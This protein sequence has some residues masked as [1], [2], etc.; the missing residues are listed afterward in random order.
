MIHIIKTIR[1]VLKD[2]PTIKGYCGDPARIYIVSKPVLNTA[3][4]SYP[5]ITMNM[6]DG[7]SD[8]VTNVADGFIYIHIWTKTVSGSSGGFTTGQLIAKR[9]YELIDI[10]QFSS[11][12]PKIYKIF[13]VNT[14]PLF[15]DDTQVFHHTIIF[16]VIVDGYWDPEA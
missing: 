13:R 5:Q 6:Q 11:V 9:I 15:E 10:K 12:T 1:D 8:T 2:D 16:R 3:S 4:G 7:S 14:V